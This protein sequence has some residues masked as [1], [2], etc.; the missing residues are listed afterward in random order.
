MSSDADTV[1]ERVAAT[2]PEGDPNVREQLALARLSKGLA[3]GRAPAPTIDR[4]VVLERLGEGG[5]GMV[6]RA[7]DPRMRREVALKVLR[8]AEGADASEGAQTR[9]LREGQALAQL[10]HPNVV[11]VYDVERTDR[12]VCVV[13]EYV[14]G[15]TL[16]TW[17]ESGT[18]VARIIE[19]AIDIAKGLDAAHRQRLVHRDVKPDN[20]LIGD[21]GR[22]RI[23]DF[24]LARGVAAVG[25]LQPPKSLAGDSD[26]LGVD[27]QDELT[28]AGTVVGTVGYMAP[29]QHRG[30]PATAAADQYALCI[31]LWE[32]VYGAR[33]FS[34]RGPALVEAKEGPLPPRPSRAVPAWFHR[35]L[36]RG[37]EPRPADR[38]VSC[39]A[40]AS[41]L[42]RGSRRAGHRT[43]AAALSAVGLLVAA[44]FAG[45]RWSEH[46]RAQQCAQQSQLGFDAP[47]L[48]SW[49][50]R[51][52][53][54]RTQDCIATTIEGTLDP[55]S[56]EMVSLC[57]DEAR[58]EVKGLA[59]AGPAPPDLTSPAPERCRD[60]QQ[61]T[62]RPALP[63]AA[64]RRAAAREL[65]VALAEV[66]GRTRAGAPGRAAEA[67]EAAVALDHPPLVAAAQ[68]EVGRAGHDESSEA[69]LRA[70]F[71]ACDGDLGVA[72]D[73]AV[74]LLRRVEGSQRRSGEA[75]AWEATA[76]MLVRR[77]GAQDEPVGRAL[78]TLRT[79]G[80]EADADAERDAARE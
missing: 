30:E 71:E 72:A 5:M 77:I 38:W 48:D 22:V 33:P 9:L 1:V 3:G 25:S 70:A 69:S 54:T 18:T 73:A 63:E 39:A 26:D 13:M 59:A 28:K 31:T 60:A 49:A 7:Y 74:E 27:S 21:D 4:Y 66:R 68:L 15:T 46:R 78:E 47:G 75:D 29:E 79:S 56:F 35:I 43:V 11:E 45:Q 24:G 34:G 6:L 37:L 76:T 17:V 12:G 20:I 41:A 2:A 61:R 44:T 32:A 14:A 58:A 42:E 36:A 8:P 55:A 62:R 40:L 80:L 10:R 57:L 16:R 19:A 52:S 23:A 64:E 51:W 65:Y 67:L 50:N 53:Q